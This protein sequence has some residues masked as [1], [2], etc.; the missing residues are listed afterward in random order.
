MDLVPEQAWG[1]TKNALWEDSSFAVEVKFDLPATK[2]QLEKFLRDPEQYFVRNLKRKS[3]EVSEKRMSPEEK[4]KFVEAK[5]AEV[6]K[7][8]SARALEALPPEQRPDPHQALRMRWILTYKEDDQGGKKPKARAVL[9]GYMDPD[10]ANRPT[11][12]P[13][14]TRNS[15]QM[16]LQYCAWQKM[17]CWK[18][19]VQGAFLQ[20]RQ[21]E[22]ELHCIPVP[23][24]CEGLG[25][26]AGSV[27]R[28]RK[29]CYGLVEAPIEWFEAVNSYLCSLG[30]KQMRSDPCTWIYTEG[31]RVIS[32]ISGH[33]DDFLF[34]G[35]ADCPVW[36]RLQSAIQAK[37]QWQE[38]ELNN[39]TQCGVQV[40]RAEDGSFRLCQKHYLEGVSEIQV[41]RDRRRD[42]HAPT[43]DFEKS[44]LRALF[45]ALSWHVGQVGFKYS[46]HVS[47]GLS[48]IPV[49]TVGHLEQANKLL[50]QVRQDAKTP[51]IIHAFDARSKLVMTAWCDASDR[52]RHDGQSTEGIFIGLSPS[53]LLEGMVA[54]VSPVFWKSGRIDRVC[55]SPGSAEA[56]AAIDAED[57]LYLMRYAWG[58]FCGMRPEVAAPEDH[59]RLVP[60]ILVTDSRN[61]YDRL[62]R[63]YITPKGAQ[64]KIDI[65]LLS[66][67][68]AQNTTGLIIRW[69]HSDA[70]LA[71]TLTKRGEEHQVSRFLALEQKWRI[72][73]DPNMFSG[74]RRRSEG[75]DPLENSGNVQEPRVSDVD[76]RV[77]AKQQSTS[78]AGGHASAES[79][80]GHLLC[81]GQTSSCHRSCASALT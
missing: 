77:F 76:A 26:P 32:I 78:G 65:E 5:L 34:A 51:M 23:E 67:K 15:R 45:G 27:C 72:V 24:L 52:N 33:V 58:E 49:S 8:L 14:M 35:H 56:R 25:L 44:Q 68:E 61:V 59:V 36:K 2:K 74:R 18:G 7:F 17:S 4:K 29:A 16:L 60:G 37:F 80:S 3:V 75:M 79:T 22:R 57:N 11:F 28:L 21:Y 50:H 42:K 1:T 12:A 48:E 43:T 19:D 46:A 47:L 69:V 64:K 9:L 38:W 66:L 54:K 53:N 31:D 62:I 40:S 13:T 70:Q 10:Y 30:Y 71:N 41:S 73:D 63:P 6:K 39:F 20:G 55:R 81:A